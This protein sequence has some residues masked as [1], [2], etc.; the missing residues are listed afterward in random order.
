ME[1]ICSIKLTQP[2]L[3]CSLLHDPL[4]P[5]DTDIISGGSLTP[6]PESAQGLTRPLPFLARGGEKF[7]LL[8]DLRGGKMVANSYTVGM[9]ITVFGLIFSAA[10]SYLTQ[11]WNSTSLTQK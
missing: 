10:A 8:G 11:Q 2:P 3:L 9:G 7:H 4:L 6:T 1:L 5:F